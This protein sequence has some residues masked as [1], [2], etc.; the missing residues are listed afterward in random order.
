MMKRKSQAMQSNTNQSQPIIK[1]TEGG[2]EIKTKIGYIEHKH[3]W[4]KEGK[5]V[6][7]KTCT[8]QLMDDDNTFLKTYDS[9]RVSK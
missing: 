5:W 2:I 4:Y 9:K 8:M 1:E 6:K 3:E 7:C